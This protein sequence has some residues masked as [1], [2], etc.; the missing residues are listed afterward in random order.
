MF[1]VKGVKQHG[2]VEVPVARIR[3]EISERLLFA[4]ELSG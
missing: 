1:I 4:T 3:L 2:P